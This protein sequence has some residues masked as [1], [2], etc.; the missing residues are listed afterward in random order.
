MKDQEPVQDDRLLDWI[1]STM[2]P[3]ERARMNALSDREPSSPGEVEQ[4]ERLE[5]LL[6]S[7]PSHTA[8]THLWADLQHRIDKA[9][10]ESSTSPVHGPV[11]TRVRV[12]RRVMRH[13]KAVAGLAAVLILAVSLFTFEPGLFSPSSPPT[14]QIEW[15]IIEEDELG[16][17]D[18][19]LQAAT[20]WPTTESGS[21]DLMYREL[22]GGSK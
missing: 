22:V 5:K 6:S 17:E 21:P 16:L 7:L 3:S 11:A 4:R 2:D 14:S 20:G 15:V 19:L 10:A 12:I 18:D 9:P 13:R 1:E 8:P